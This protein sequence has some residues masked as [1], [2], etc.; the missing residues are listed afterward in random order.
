MGPRSDE[1]EW[2]EVA[3]SLHEIGAIQFGEFR[4]TSG[5][6]SP[7]YIDLRLVPSYPRVF[8]GVRDLCVKTLREIGDPVEKIAG[9]PVSGLP[10]ATAVSMKL[11]RPLI[12]VRKGRKHHGGEK[13]VE[14]FLNPGERVVLVDDVTTTGGSLEGAA[15]G[16]RE[17]G[18][19]VEHAVIVIDREEGGRK[20]LSDEGIALHA[21]MKV[22]GVVEYLHHDGSLDDENFSAVIEYLKEVG[23][24][25]RP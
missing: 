14:G 20:R 9:V 23:R 7:Y 25:R 12:F 13:L 18:G 3:T 2:Q 21:C 11:N 8:R 15:H 4:L 5:R 16:I 19:K 10:L 22:G 24:G 6:T 17:E 1:R